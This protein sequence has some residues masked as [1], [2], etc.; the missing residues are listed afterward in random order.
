MVARQGWEVILEPE[1]TAWIFDLPDDTHDRVE[2]AIDILAQTG[3]GVGWPLVDTIT[4]SRHQYKKEL[5]VGTCR[6][7]FAF[8]PAR[9]AILL[10]AGD[11]RGN[12]RT[13]YPPAIALADQRFDNWLTDLKGVFKRERAT[14]CS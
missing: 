4:G 9:T 12:W 2:A 3:A 5:R 14:G 1:V 10:V 6:I 11:K 8:D 13:W 7:L